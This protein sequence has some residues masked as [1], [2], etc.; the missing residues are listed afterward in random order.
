MASNPKLILLKIIHTL[1]WVFFNVVIFYLLYAV[2][3]DKIDKWVWICVGLVILEGVVLLIFNRF[4]PITLIA[5]KYSDS[6]QDNFD[7]Y[8]PNWLARYNKEIYTTIFLV[9]C[10]I[11][12]YRLLT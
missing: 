8:L 3:A 1:I 5:R 7:I 2:I 9:A 11:L 10:A 6:Q 4:C 12:V